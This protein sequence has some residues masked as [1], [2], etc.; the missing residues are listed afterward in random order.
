[1]AG[2]VLALWLD[3]WWA[4]AVIV[5]VA[6]YNLAA[7]YLPERVRTGGHWAASAV[8]A[9]VVGY[10]LTVYWE[11]L[12]PER[13][14]A[15]NLIFV[16]VLIGGLMA[17][18]MLFRLVYGRVLAFFLRFKLLF[19]IIPVVLTAFGVW[20]VWLGPASVFG[21][22][23]NAR[24]LA[25]DGFPS[26]GDAAA[27]E[28]AGLLVK[29]EKD[30]IKF[31][32]TTKDM[33]I[34]S[35]LDA[36][37]AAGVKDGEQ[38]A[39]LWLKTQPMAELAK[40]QW[41]YPDDPRQIGIGRSG[42]AVEA[43]WTLAR[44]W[45]GRGKEFMP[46]LDEGTFLLMPTNMPHASIGATMDVLQKQDRA[47]RGIPE[48]ESV[49][50]K[51]G[52]AE[53]SLDPAG[54]EM[55]ETVISYKPEYMTDKD[56]RRLRFRYDEQAAKFVRDEKGQLI[57]D[58]N[59]R[60]FRQ[61]RDQIK[62]PNDIWDAI[63]EAAS[64]PGT[65]SAPKLQPI[66]A[67]RVMLQSGMR[68][69]MGVKISGPDLDS[70]Q[71]AGLDV[72]RLLKEVPSVK[73][74][75]VFADR[76]LG[77]PYLEIVPNRQAIAR[78]G[79]N[80]GD[81]LNVVETAV[82]GMVATTT[83]EGRERYAVR[84][85][86]ERELRAQI[87]SLGGILV[88]TMGAAQIPL[89]DLADVRYATGPMDIKSEDG[90]LVGYVLFDRKPGTAEVD[91]VEECQ[92]YLEQKIAGGELALPAGVS[93][94]FAGDYENELHAHKTLSIVLPLALMVIFLILYFQFRAVSTALLVFSSV[95][96]AWSGGFML[97]W[98]YGQ[99][100]F[101]RFSVF[102]VPMR[103]LFQMH[104]INMSVAVW[105]GFLALFGIAVDDGV[106]IATY[107]DQSFGREHPDSVEGIREATLA[108]GKRRIR[109][110]LMTVA[111]AILALIPV[112]TSVG[113]GSDVMVPM[114]IP[115][116]GGMLVVL[117]SV[118]TVPVFYCTIKEF[119]HIT[120]WSAAAVGALLV[121]TAFLPGMA[122]MMIVTA[123]VR[124]RPRPAVQRG[125]L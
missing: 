93:Y 32:W 12:G 55:I 90:A 67:R 59:G 23:P 7:E 70:I 118:F 50:G 120:G 17:F 121:V 11:P 87:E 54:M 79:I 31:A 16:G 3:W 61:W 26:P 9:V 8:A 68:A 72:E 125:E 38:V 94:K 99:P 57:E 43:R 15:R 111:T 29:A 63:L 22:A 113:R 104:V 122:A 92:R 108:G 103:G 100:W 58:P 95:G 102:G 56:G 60:P 123:V 14:L 106:L 28:K 19:L 119:R 35:F 86:Y 51:V 65:T 85:R 80:V 82:G 124:R 21:P 115:T 117:A 105:V 66:E 46:P 24:P 40:L 45:N 73:A 20:Y 96:L 6:G 2:V 64:I 83:V 33:T 84:V 13:G 101:M 5:L 89:R 69:P 27:L 77:K 18:F 81:V 91:V 107:L 78:Y 49:V 112:L 30:S 110:C 53:T 76:I 116:F 44:D 97:L 25:A 98:A 39:H 34:R 88:P 36:V 74:D 10:L 114:A 52:R 47:I 1:M 62:T 37:G 4:G 75:A 42:L 71:Q 48:I 109:P 41:E